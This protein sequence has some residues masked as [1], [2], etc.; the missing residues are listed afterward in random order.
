MHIRLTTSSLEILAR[1]AEHL[2]AEMQTTITVL[3]NEIAT[4]TED[5]K[6]AA[7]SLARTANKTLT[8]LRAGGAP[9]PDAGQPS[10]TGRT[11]RCLAIRFE[12]PHG[13]ELETRSYPL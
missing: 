4:R 9:L 7:K 3:G 13:D 8:L 10:G 2:I 1:D 12:K 5:I 6:L 11:S